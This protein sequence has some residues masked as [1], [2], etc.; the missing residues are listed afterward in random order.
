MKPK[1][2]NEIVVNRCPNPIVLD[3]HV[4]TN[5]ALGWIKKESI[6]YS[7]DGLL[8]DYLTR[9]NAPCNIVFS[10]S[11]CFDVEEVKKHLESPDFN[12][13]EP[14]RLIDR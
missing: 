9:K 7:S 13:E 3:I 14:I 4:A 10:V 11:P 1:I 6:K 12:A 8:R 2:K 5:R